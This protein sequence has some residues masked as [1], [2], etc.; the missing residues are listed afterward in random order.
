MRDVIASI[1]AEYRRYRS[2]AEGAIDQLNGGQL[3]TRVSAESLSIATIAWH[4]SGN[5]E[6]RFTEFLTSDGEKDWRQREDEFAV[7]TAMVEILE[8]LDFTVLEAADGQS[9]VEIFASQHEAITLVV[10]E[11]HAATMLLAV[12]GALGSIR[13]YRQRQG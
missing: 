8:E 9:A 10:P 1:E 11:P 13:R 5:L 3:C 12:L 6:S 2:L 4:I 7:R